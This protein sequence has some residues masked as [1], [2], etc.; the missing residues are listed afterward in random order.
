GN[1]RQ[2]SESLVISVEGFEVVS[3]SHIRGE[4]WAPAE[5]DRKR[6][7][8][9]LKKFRA[10][11]SE[12]PTV[13]GW[14]RTHSRPGL[15]LDNRD[16]ELVKSF[17]PDPSCVALL[18]RPDTANPMAG[19]FFWEA[20]EMQRSQPYHSFPFK[21]LLLASAATTAA[22]PVAAKGVHPG[23][24][25]RRARVSL[26][27]PLAN[28]GSWRR[29]AVLIAPVAAGLAFGVFW[30]PQPLVRARQVD[31]AKIISSVKDEPRTVFEP[32]PLVA[33]PDETGVYT[34]P[35]EEGA[36]VEVSEK[37]PKAPPVRKLVIPAPV[38]KPPEPV[39]DVQA[40]V[41][42]AASRYQG[43]PAVRHVPPRATA[44]VE[45][46]RASSLR[47]AVGSIPGLGFLKRRKH[48]S[49]GEYTSAR[50]VREVRPISPALLAEEVPVK[51]R[52]LV[53]PRGDVEKVELLSRK[54][55]TNVAQLALD[56]ASKWHFEP[57]RLD[58]KPVQS[59]MI[60]QFR[61][62]ASSKSGS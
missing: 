41:I 57:A 43:P 55:D 8:T 24:P 15:Y 3:I 32:S 44:T 25:A 53:G 49:A 1:V 54:V 39:L 61:F 22:S 47:R 9:A 29:K 11:G 45:P 28:S 46:V 51:I 37:K 56:A 59:E 2:S 60:L 17:F 21:D 14:F 19:F 42:T 50:P 16:F 10:R 58:E 30:D 18:I 62:G 34:P 31:L 40:P 6:L 48:S 20:G 23:V 13:V 36:E 12:K 4:S 35:Q 5:R 52:L 27:K 26:A 38:R 7:V 33:P